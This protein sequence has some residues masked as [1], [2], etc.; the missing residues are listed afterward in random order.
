MRL[1]DVA[2]LLSIAV[3]MSS[4]AQTSAIQTRDLSRGAILPPTSAALADEATAPS[5]NPAGLAHL[6]DVQL[7]YLHERYSGFG[8]LSR[9]ADALHLGASIFGLFTAGFGLDWVRGNFVPSYRKTH[10]TLA[11]GGQELSLG[12]NLN[13]FS[14]GSIS[15]L[16]GLTSIDVGLSSRPLKYLALGAVLR[17]ADKPSRE[18]LSFDREYDFGLGLRPF[19]D[20]VTVA[21]DYLFTQD[22]GIG[23]GRFSYT[24][25]AEAFRGLV[26][27]AGFSHALKDAPDPLFQ[28]SATLNTA[29]LGAT[30]SAGGVKGGF[31][32]IIALRVSREK[33]RALP[34]THRKTAL[35]DL[36]QHLSGGSLLPFFGLAIDPYLR[37]IRFLSEA[38]RDEDLRGII[39]KIDLLPNTGFGKIQELREGIF[40]LRRA[41]KK[42][43]AFIQMAE[44]SEYF[45]ATAAD[46]IYVAP[47][48]VLLVNGLAANAIFLGGA[49][50][51]VGVH[52][53]VA[54]V[55]DYKN[56]PD[57]LTRSQMS[58][59]QKETIDAYL[60]V[61]IHLFEDAVTGSRSI[62][63]DQFRA[64]LQ[65]GLL[66]PARAKQLGLIDGV[67][68]EQDLEHRIAQLV[69]G[70][71]YERHYEPNDRRDTAWGRPRQ[72]AIIPVIGTIATGK[73]R[74]DPFGLVPI[75]GS[76]TVV[77]ML[78]IASED[79][80]VAAIVLRVDS[81]GGDGL[82]SDL[83]YRAALAAKKKKPLIAS[84]GD[85]AASGGYYASM[86]ADEVFA[87]PSTITGSIGV[88]MVKPAFENL[89]SKLGIHQDT[90]KRGDF[91]GIFNLFK[92]WSA[93]ERIAAQRWVDS[94]YDDFISEVSSARKL[95][96]EEVDKV[97]R[98]RVWAG[99]D[100]KSRNLIDN[101]GSLQHAISAARRRAR[102]PDSEEVQLEI[103][104][105][106]S[107]LL[108]TLLQDAAVRTS[109]VAPPAPLPQALGTL[110]QEVGITSALFLEPGVKAMM[111]FSLTVR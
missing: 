55:G 47:Q 94:F 56:A 78:R 111:P 105:E 18:S 5:I 93:E 49:M 87:E 23:G 4:V 88:F 74:Q 17:N 81:G 38:E 50:D 24:L 68:G 96:K 30:Y 61:N 22:R 89:A 31:N 54:R 53:D 6:N 16:D 15:S 2:C 45:L 107:G 9:N 40:R 19:G 7:L 70:T 77:R 101:F 102:I 58:A 62:Q 1:C 108:G 20:S 71:H 3:P 27:S 65:D 92:P 69:P 66:T 41:G 110:A 91:A 39:L 33:Y 82:A 100:A 51:K 48:A 35:I 34:I 99:A 80:S 29:H 12:V 44:D 75:S 46:Q 36:R 86:A 26:L 98:G 37:F 79:P 90:I 72:I 97:A 67:E 73:S 8:S 76:D 14:S 13:V 25:Q 52:W 63:V 43:I 85:V 11:L 103:M 109:L 104:N 64:A 21:A 28:L 95:Q 59:A 42:V 57:Q 32:D 83:M 84:M 106:G 10:W 60:D